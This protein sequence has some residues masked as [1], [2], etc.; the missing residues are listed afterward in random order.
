[1]D[2]ITPESIIDAAT[3]YGWTQA[4]QAAPFTWIIDTYLQ[5]I[6][7]GRE[8]LELFSY[9]VEAIQYLNAIHALMIESQV[10]MKAAR[11]ELH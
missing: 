1:M 3:K 10:Y 8:D 4:E 5:V 7:E 9:Y 11:S 2:N 6:C